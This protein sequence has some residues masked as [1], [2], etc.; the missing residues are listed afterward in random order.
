MHLFPRFYWLLA[1]LPLLWVSLNHTEIVTTS[2]PYT[3]D[4]KYKPKRVDY[5]LI[6]NEGECISNYPQN[7]IKMHWGDTLNVLTLGIN[8]NMSPLMYAEHPHAKENNNTNAR[9]KRVVTNDAP[10]IYKRYDHPEAG[11]KMGWYEFLSGCKLDPTH[12]GCSDSQSQNQ[13]IKVLDFELL[14]DAGNKNTC[15]TLNG[16]AIGG[17]RVPPPDIIIDDP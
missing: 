14:D 13:S 8:L 6:W 15:R 2:H 10:M 17:P 12:F 16:E 9:K 1:T 4:T 7:T 3:M 11:G 5:I